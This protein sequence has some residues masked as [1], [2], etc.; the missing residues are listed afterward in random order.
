M[1]DKTGMDWP[2]V[3]DRNRKALL[4]IIVTLMASLGVLGGG[5]LTTLPLFLYRR[6]LSIIRP[7]ESALRRLIVIVAHEMALRGFKLRVGK[8][9]GLDKF[10]ISLRP[11]PRDEPAI[12]T[13][14][15]IDPLKSF[16]REAPDVDGFEFGENSD[17]TDMTHVPAASLHARILA[18]KNALENLPRQAKRLARWY[19]QRDLAYSQNLPHRYS[20]MRPGPAPFSRKRKDHEVDEVLL[21]CHL[22]AI[23]AGERQDSS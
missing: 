16:G 12:P 9:A 6:A 11:H 2:L 20:P 8:R 1:G 13:F 10:L 7:A 18:L 19:E 23:Y 22:L 21:E 15:L 17:A 5:R 4:T 14:N 3:I